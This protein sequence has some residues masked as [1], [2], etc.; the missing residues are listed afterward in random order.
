MKPIDFPESNLDLKKPDNMTDE[1]CLT[2]PCWRGY[3]PLAGYPEGVPTTVSK[4]QLSPEEIEEVQRTG[5]VWLFQ[6][7]HVVPPSLIITEHPF[8]YPEHQITDDDAPA[9]SPTT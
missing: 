5:H 8:I 2:L 1:Q 7:S 3:S 9:S 4:W 6:Y